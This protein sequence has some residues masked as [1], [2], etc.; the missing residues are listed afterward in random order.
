MKKYVLLV[1]R[2]IDSISTIGLYAG[3]VALALGTLVVFAEVV[4]R[5]GRLAPISFAD[6]MSGYVLAFITLVAAA[7][8]YRSHILP[9]MEL[10]IRHL[11]PKV[12][13]WLELV[14]LLCGLL[15]VGILL[16]QSWGLFSQSLQHKT[17]SLT[18]LQTRLFLPQG[19]MLLGIIILELQFLSS[20]IQWVFGHEH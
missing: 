5:Y 13:H 14:T 11:P 9:R 18:I 10:A 6:E 15:F 4:I 2:A 20:T 7:E 8:S 12:R 17:T 1:S 19:A 16:D 3:A